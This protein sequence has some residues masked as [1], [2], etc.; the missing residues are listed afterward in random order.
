M[1]KEGAKGRRDGR[2]E[3]R[4]ERKSEG[5]TGREKGRGI[6]GGGDVV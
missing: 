5:G 6:I 4:K 2:K 3:G 1:K